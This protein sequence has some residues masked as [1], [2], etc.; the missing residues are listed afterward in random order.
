MER[1]DVSNGACCSDMCSDGAL[2][3]RTLL[4][5]ACVASNH[6]NKISCHETFNRTTPAT[7]TAMAAAEAAVVGDANS[8]PR[9]RRVV[10][11]AAIY[12]S[13]GHYGGTT[14]W[15]TVRLS[16]SRRCR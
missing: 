2:R 12:G 8:R 9:R 3:R 10:G 6:S 13:R 4:P 11:Q 15:T 5:S 14:A 1:A 7:M 16:V